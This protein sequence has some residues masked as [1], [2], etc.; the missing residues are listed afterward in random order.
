[1]SKPY[2]KIA[3]V[4]GRDTITHRVH[5]GVWT[6]DTLET[7]AGVPWTWTEKID[8]TNIRLIY[9]GES[10]EVRGRTDKAQLHQ[11]LLERCTE[12]AVGL[13]DIQEASGHGAIT[14]YGEG[15]GPGIQKGGA[16]YGDT[17][18]FILF[19]ALVGEGTWL[20]RQAI[21]HYAR[22]LEIREAAVLGQGTLLEAVEFVR[23]WPG[24]TGTEGLGCRPLA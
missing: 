5:E 23:S 16:R 17:K 2:P 12:I 3:N 19:D 22:K 10:V 11:D 7:L 8:G 6:S 21:E 14:L 20:P 15:C 9:D 18:D 1:M 4:F 24:D 13:K